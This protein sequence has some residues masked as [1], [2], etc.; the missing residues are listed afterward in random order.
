MGDQGA[1]RKFGT[2]LRGLHDQDWLPYASITQTG[3]LETSN[4]QGALL[5]R[6]Q[7]GEGGAALGRGDSQGN[8]PLASSRNPFRQW[9]Q[10]QPK[11]SHK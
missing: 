10:T 5:A 7:A 9:G 6:N 1:Y 4:R 3:A 2:S 11:Q 8:V